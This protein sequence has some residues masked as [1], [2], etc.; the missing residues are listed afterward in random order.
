MLRNSASIDCARI[1]TIA[2]IRYWYNIDVDHARVF[3]KELRM[4]NQIIFAS[5][6]SK[7][8][9]KHISI[10]ICLRSLGTDNNIL[11][12]FISFNL[13][14][15][16]RHRTGSL[17]HVFECFDFDNKVTSYLSMMTYTHFFTRLISKSFSALSFNHWV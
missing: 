17:M 11:E 4:A 16:S 12:S 9:E 3:L 5:S 6:F 8:F 13:S 14:C 10:N 7:C 2:E 1:L 15:A